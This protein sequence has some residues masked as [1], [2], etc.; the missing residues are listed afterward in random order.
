MGLHILR[1]LSGFSVRGTEQILIIFALLRQVPALPFQ[2]LHSFPK[3]GVFI[4]QV[5]DGLDRRGR[6]LQG[7]GGF[8]IDPLLLE[9]GQKQQQKGGGKKDQQISHY[10][11]RPSSGPGVLRLVLNAA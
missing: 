3:L 4:D 7:V 1:K 2:L 8:G 11:R 6:L 10:G 5:L 9:I